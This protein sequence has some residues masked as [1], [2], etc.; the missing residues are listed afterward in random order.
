MYFCINLFNGR[1]RSG[2]KASLFWYPIIAVT[3]FSCR[4]FATQPDRGNNGSGSWTLAP[5]VV[6]VTTARALVQALTTVNQSLRN[7]LVRFGVL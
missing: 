7:I 2:L 4:T 3:S 5:K 6:G 1:G